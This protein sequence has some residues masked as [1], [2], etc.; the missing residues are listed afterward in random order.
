MVGGSI[1]QLGEAGTRDPGET[2]RTG[3]QDELLLVTVRLLA[4]TAACIVIVCAS[5]CVRVRCTTQAGPVVMALQH[6]ALWQDRNLPWPEN[7]NLTITSVRC[8]A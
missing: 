6:T 8:K 5:A 7:N 4:Y 3:H 1:D 2:H